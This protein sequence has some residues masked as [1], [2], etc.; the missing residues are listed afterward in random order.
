MFD[1]GTNFTQEYR[2]R[3]DAKLDGIID[4]VADLKINVITRLD[5]IER[6]LDLVELPH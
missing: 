4:D 2:R 3:M 5:G 6:R 1:D